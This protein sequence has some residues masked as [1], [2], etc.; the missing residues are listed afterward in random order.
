MLCVIVCDHCK[1][2]PSTLVSRLYEHSALCRVWMGKQKQEE[3]RVAR[4]FTSNPTQKYFIVTRNDIV[5]L[6]IEAFGDNSG[7]LNAVIA[8]HA[9]LHSPVEQECKLPPV[10]AN[11]CK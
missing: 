9:D 5:L 8:P 1:C 11:K 4:A 10:V 7:S 6:A 3:Q 2:S